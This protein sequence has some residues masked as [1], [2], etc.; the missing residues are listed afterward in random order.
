VLPATVTV[1]GPEL[2]GRGGGDCIVDEDGAGRAS[3]ASGAG[4]ACYPGHA[5]RI[6]QPGDGRAERKD[7]V[8][9]AASCSRRS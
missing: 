1:P 3:W 4:R 7:W 2:G 5:E 6:P 8:A 9:D